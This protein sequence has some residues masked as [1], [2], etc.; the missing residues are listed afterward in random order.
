M[1]ACPIHCV[2]RSRRTNAQARAALV[3]DCLKGFTDDEEIQQAFY[4]IEYSEFI[5]GT[6]FHGSKQEREIDKLLRQFANLAL[7]WQA[8]LVSTADVR[9]VH[10][11]VKRILKDSGISKYLEFMEIWSAGQG[12]INRPY[13]VLTKMERALEKSCLKL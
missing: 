10:Y 5:Y 6:D 12:V 13:G 7:S 9:P 3:A 8:G 11:Y 4:A 2:E 1:Q